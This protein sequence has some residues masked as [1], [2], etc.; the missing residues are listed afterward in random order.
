M[1]QAPSLRRRLA[2]IVYEGLLLFGVSVA[3]GLVYSPLMQQR[4]ALDHRQGLMFVLCISY[5][6]YFCYFWTRG[7]QTLAMKTWRLQLVTAEG[8]PLSIGL[9]L[10]RFTLSLMWWV[11]P[12]AS[13]LQLRP[14]GFGFG[15]IAALGI[16]GA[17]GYALISRRLPG[18]QFLHDVLSGTALVDKP[19]PARS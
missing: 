9:A 1:P 4:H 13:F 11:L 15:P 10:R 5:A 14:L 16:L 2:C 3:V 6:L 8:R 7:G 12:V 17:L 19:T 18:R